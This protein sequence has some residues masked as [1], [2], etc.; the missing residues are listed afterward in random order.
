MF[1]KTRFLHRFQENY[2]VVGKHDLDEIMQRGMLPD[3]CL[4]VSLDAIRCLKNFPNIRHLILTSGLISEDD[5]PYL[6]GLAIR[7][8]MLDY[9]AE[10]DDL[11]TIDLS[12]FPQLELVF[13]ITEHGFRNVEKCPRIC[14]LIVQKWS[15]EDL[16][17]LSGSRVRALKIL[18]GKLKS[19]NGV[20]KMRELLSLDVSNQRYLANMSALENNQL[21]SFALITCNKI[22]LAMIPAM[23]CARMIH[24]E[25]NARIQS[26]GDLLSHFPKVEWLLLGNVVS[27][28][29]LSA[30]NNLSHAVVFTDCRHYSHKNRELPKSSGSF[31]SHY[32]PS[33]LEILPEAYKK[34]ITETDQV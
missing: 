3:A 2:L 20:D 15:S 25:G 9:Y 30:L 16:S 27:D 5:L 7:A 21:E 24:L 18:S 10:E 34:S 22:D 29:D 17:R 28:G 12:Q 4:E 8:L 32:L 11:W 31:H 33:H 14:T 19:M 13:S 1:Y 23:P 26:A 6:R